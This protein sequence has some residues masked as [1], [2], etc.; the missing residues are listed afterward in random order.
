MFWFWGQQACGILTL[1]PG[2]ELTSPA[3]EGKVL[4]SEPPG[5][6]LILFFVFVSQSK[7]SVHRK[8]NLWPEYDS[9]QGLP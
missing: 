5:K 9:Q 4:T 3:L 7:E 1:C 6:S 8:P 2:I